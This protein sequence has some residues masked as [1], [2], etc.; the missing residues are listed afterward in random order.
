VKKAF[1]NSSRT[2]FSSSDEASEGSTGT[3]RDL[4]LAEGMK[5]SPE[6]GA[7]T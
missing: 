7:L 3:V 5:N 6:S 1:C 4:D 2:V